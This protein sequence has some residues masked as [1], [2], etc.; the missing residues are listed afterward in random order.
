MTGGMN[1]LSF[2]ELIEAFFHTEG[3]R[4]PRREIGAA[5]CRCDGFDV[6]LHHDGTL[7]A[8]NLHAYIDLGPVPPA[9]R[10]EIFRGLLLNQLDCAPPCRTV[11]GL[12]GSH[13]HVV[14]VMRIAFDATLDGAGLAETLRGSIRQLLAWPPTTPGAP[15]RSAKGRR[16]VR[17]RA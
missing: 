12:E 16:A 7:D 6:A 10:R 8:D 11:V 4:E 3:I 14:L 1:R 5:R 9:G 15:R 2:V 13:G 17:R